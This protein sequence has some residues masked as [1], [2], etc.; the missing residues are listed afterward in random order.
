MKR[1][2]IVIK[3]LIILATRSHANLWRSVFG[4]RP[5][6]GDKVI[7]NTGFGTKVEGTVV[8]VNSKD[9]Y[10]WIEQADKSMATASFSYC[11]FIFVN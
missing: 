5:V 7:T 6:K 9:G 1:L 3:K 8:S 11:T 2:I 10:C 4:M